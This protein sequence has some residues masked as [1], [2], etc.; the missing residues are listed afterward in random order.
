MKYARRM[1]RSVLSD[2]PWKR[3][4]FLIAIPLMFYGCLRASAEHD[5]RTE[6]SVRKMISRELRAGAT[7]PQVE[8]FMRQHTPDAWSFD[9]YGYEFMG[10]MPQSK[11]DKMRMDR[12]VQIRIKMH[13][14]TDTIKR[15]EVSPSYTFL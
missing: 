10:L 2:F 6:Q 11:L 1:L 8:L 12:R 7:R 4:L 5:R 15:V 14:G 13:R 9:S 3:L